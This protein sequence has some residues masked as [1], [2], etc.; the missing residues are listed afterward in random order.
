MSTALREQTINT[1]TLGHYSERTI[2]TYIDW[3][4]RISQHYNRSPDELSEQEVQA[5]KGSANES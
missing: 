3:L 2:K 4:I 5:E 1:L